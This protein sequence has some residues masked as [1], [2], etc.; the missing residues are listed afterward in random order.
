MTGITLETPSNVEIVSYFHCGPLQKLRTDCS[1]TTK[2]KR[3][4]ASYNLIEQQKL[5]LEKVMKSIVFAL[6]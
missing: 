4:T 3:N 6:F 2:L 1:T 5:D